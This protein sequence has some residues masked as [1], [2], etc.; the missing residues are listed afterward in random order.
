MATPSVPTTNVGI[1]DDLRVATA[2]TQTTN[3]SLAS[4]CNGGTYNGIQNTFGASGGKAM[5]FDVIGGT[6]NPITT[7]PNSVNLFD[8][9]IGTA[10]FNLAN[11]IG[12]RYT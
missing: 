3:L 8:D 4:L 1:N 11:T 5:F 9:I 6:N 7:T 2:C 12:G 10:P